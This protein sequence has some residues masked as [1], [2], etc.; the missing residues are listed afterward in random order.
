MKAISHNL[1]VLLTGLALAGSVMTAA[2][3]P[4]G[5]LD[6][7]KRPDRRSLL[8]TAAG[9]RDAEAT[10]DL[11]I[12]NVRARIMTGGDMWWD[13]GTGEAR[14][15]VPKG[16][17]KNAL[18]AGSLWVGGFDTQGQLKVT[19]QTF[20][21]SGN[22]YWTGPL[23]Q[24]NSIDEA[25]CTQWDR[26]WKVNRSDVL[27][28]RDMVAQGQQEALRNNPTYA[29][30]REWPARG[31]IDAIGSD[32]AQLRTLITSPTNL[33]SYAPFVDINGDGQYQWDL[34]DYPSIDVND[35][36]GVTPNG[37]PDQY[38]F[39]IYNDVGNTKTQT[40]TDGIGL[41]V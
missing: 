6:G 13:R 11:D 14:Y 25:T 9:C 23:D 7:N 36:C 16:S 38:I 5:E 19:A 30:I 17:K 4:T 2:A 3:R 12:N 32:G 20:R 21:Q 22:D 40:G 41:E 33:R 31:N 35:E 28:F 8:K 34:G 26:F 29:S 27:V 1:S 10:I 18:F 39:S 37:G 24:F 15:E